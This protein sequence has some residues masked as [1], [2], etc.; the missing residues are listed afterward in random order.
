M[1][2]AFMGLATELPDG[3]NDE[4]TM[5]FTIPP[6]DVGQGQ[7]L[8]PG[9]VVINWVDAS[10]AEP[11]DYLADLHKQFAEAFDNFEVLE[12]GE[13][14]P[15]VPFIRFQFDA[16]QDLQ[17]MLAVRRVGSRMVIVTGTAMGEYF[18]RYRE[19]F[20]GVALSLKSA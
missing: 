20:A 10:N 19:Q 15:S 14:A 13:L 3:W 2:A 5:T 4:S 1:R 8:S 6:I 11:A 17:Q 9:N 16:G 7:A 18:E 12:E